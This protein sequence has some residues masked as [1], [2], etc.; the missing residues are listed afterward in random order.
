MRVSQDELLFINS[1]TKG[2]EP[3]GVL[4]RYP[5]QEKISGFKKE[6]IQTLQMKQI[7]NENQKFT[8]EGAALLLLWEE[9]R[10]SRKHLIL[11]HI[12]LAICPKGRVIGITKQEN[13]YEIF[14]V[15]GAVVMTAL[16]KKYKF[17]RMETR[18]MNCE[19]KKIPYADWA[20]EMER[21]GENVIITGVF[22]EREPETEEVFY[23]SGDKGCR[24]EIASCWQST[25]SPR[26]MR[27]CLLNDL[28]IG[29]EDQ[30]GR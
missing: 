19:Q 28:G 7:L 12:I 9:Y 27:M 21:Y 26:T 24:Y 17:L 14:S 1:V 6:V 5:G 3:F 25:M 20:K 8:K 23:W 16:L 22:H 13:G 29:R 11:N 2:P 15:H 30:D 4:L 18:G 10:N